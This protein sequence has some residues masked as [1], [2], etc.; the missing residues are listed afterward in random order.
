MHVKICGS[1]FYASSVAGAPSSGA[2]VEVTKL[3]TDWRHQT[4]LLCDVR[5]Y[6][7]LRQFLLNSP[8]R[9]CNATSAMKVIKVVLCN[10]IG[11]FFWIQCNRLQPAKY[12][13]VSFEIVG[14][15]E[16]DRPDQSFDEDGTWSGSR[17][18]Q[19]RK[20]TLHC[21]VRATI[22]RENLDRSVRQGRHLQDL[23]QLRRHD[24]TS[25]DH[26][27]Q[28]RLIENHMKTGRGSPGEDALPG[29][30]RLDLPVDL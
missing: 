4:L 5:L 24:L 22:I 12:C 10:Q 14:P 3:K 9:N 21:R 18:L 29:E 13:L 19:D 16:Q 1:N 2:P 11:C 6:R 26:P 27:V 7:E 17:K 23:S 20:V 8:V 28:G 25:A 15:F 30:F